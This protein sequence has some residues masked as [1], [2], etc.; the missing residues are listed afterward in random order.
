MR[1]SPTGHAT[2]YTL[3]AGAFAMVLLMGC[4]GCVRDTDAQYRNRI[5]RLNVAMQSYR[6]MYGY[7]PE[8]DD[9]RTLMIKL[10]GE[11]NYIKD[12]ASAS[13]ARRLDK[14]FFEAREGDLNAQMELLGKD[15][16]PLD[17]S[18]HPQDGLILN[19]S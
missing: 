18:S 12:K 19:E 15:G 8:A 4:A 6:L 11:A 13:D 10:M 9:N 1:S 5:E 17:I 3:S 2:H 16:H 14:V 7:F